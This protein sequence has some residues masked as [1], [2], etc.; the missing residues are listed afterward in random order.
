MKIFKFPMWSDI[1]VIRIEQ[2]LHLPV[3]QFSWENIHGYFGFATVFTLAHS[4]CHKERRKSSNTDEAFHLKKF[5]FPIASVIFFPHIS[6][7]T[8]IKTQELERKFMNEGNICMFPKIGVPQNGWCIIENP[9][10]IDDLGGNTH[11]FGSTPR[12][13]RRFF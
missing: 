6:S 9:I 2:D 11:Y 3:A 1:W 7:Y 4:W 12:Y 8:V 13:L 10:K 5:M